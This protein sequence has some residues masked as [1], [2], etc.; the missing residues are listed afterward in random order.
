MDEQTL[1]DPQTRFELRPIG[2]IH[3]VLTSRHDAPKQGSEGAPDFVNRWV[4]WGASLRASQFLILGGKAR[5][6]LRGRYNVSC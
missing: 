1:P 2:V 4:T 3:S 6:V 5:A